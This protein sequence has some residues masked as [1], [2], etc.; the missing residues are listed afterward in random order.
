MYWPGYIQG[1]WIGGRVIIIGQSASRGG[2]PGTLAG[3]CIV[4][5][6]VS[7]TSEGKWSNPAWLCWSGYYRGNVVVDSQ[8][9]LEGDI[10]ICQ[11]E[12]C[13]ICFSRLADDSSQ[14]SVRPTYLGK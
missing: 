2:I 13:Q 5:W 3:I 8:Y 14:V 4:G 6:I 11:E 9:E 10:S 1:S 7:P 12:G